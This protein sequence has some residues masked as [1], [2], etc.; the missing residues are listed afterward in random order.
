MKRSIKIL[1]TLIVTTIILTSSYILANAYT[2]TV[3]KEGFRYWHA[4]RSSS[5]KF[6]TYGQVM[7][8]STSDGKVTYCIAP[9]EHQVNGS[10]YELH[11]YDAANL[12]ELINN[13]Q[14]KEINK[15]TPEQ[16]KKIALY[17]YFGYNYPNH[18]TLAYRLATQ[19]LIWRV[20]DSSQVF[21]NKLAN[22]SDAKVLS[23]EEVGVASEIAEIQRLVDQYQVWPSFNLANVNLT[24]GESTTLTDTTGVLSNFKVT[25]CTNCTAS[26]N[27]NTLNINATS[28]GDLNVTLATDTESV[29][30][31]PAYFAIAPGTQN[32]V[33]PGRIDPTIAAVRGTVTGGK[34]KIT[35]LDNDTKACSTVGD[36]TLEGAEYTIFNSNNEAVEVLRIGNDCTA[37]SSILALGNYTIKETSAPTGYLID[38]ITKNFTI[39]SE[40]AG[41]PLSLTFYEEP[42]KFALNLYKIMS[43]GSTGL[44]D[45]EENATFDVYL[46]RNN[47]KVGTIT[48]NKVGKGN[49]VLPYGKYYLKQT[50]GAKGHYFSPD[51]EVLLTSKDESVFINNADATAEIKV[52]K[53]DTDT[54]EN[55][56]LSGIKFKIWNVDKKKWVTF[57]LNYPVKK[58]IEV[59]ETDENG[60]FYTPYPLGSGDYILYEVDQKLDGYLWNKEGIKFTIDVDTEELIVLNFE[61][62]APRGTVEVLKNGEVLI[63]EEGKCSYDLKNLEGV[64]IGIYAE[65]DIIHNGNVI[66]KADEL[67]TT[68]ITD[69]EGKAKAEDLYLGKYYLKEIKTLEDYELSEV[70]YSFELKYQD[71]YTEIITDSE[72]LINYLKK[73][74]VEFYKKDFSDQSILLAGANICVYTSDNDLVECLTTNE[75]GKASIKLPKGLY[76]YV[77][78]IAP[79]GYKLDESKYEFEIES[80]TEEPLIIDVLNEFIVIDV[81]KTALNDLELIIGIILLA[82]GTGCIIFSFRKIK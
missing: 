22:Q 29:Y 2:T 33:V 56:P 49:I 15:L 47:N 50:S 57:D 70:K 75:E 64:Q 55:I 38:P 58:T 30:S 40:N 76:Y 61:N 62:K 27:G 6:L 18:Q 45:P 71:Q 35:K 34:V 44:T 23:D 48:T 21:T 17:A 31:E 26:I 46:V 7:G 80:V 65:E 11:R 36:G 28:I 24:L 69:K 74:E 59:L 72:E 68:L 51:V 9:G 82:L 4:S 79:N 43:D 14:D 13:T 66:Y 16:I 78:T 81:P 41:S 60:V 3:H 39:T 52:I 20:F 8:F 25:S 32:Q 37:T 5:G 1:I 53:L 54:K 63:C 77:E 73:Q 12:K 10:S 19:M 42:Q 67:V